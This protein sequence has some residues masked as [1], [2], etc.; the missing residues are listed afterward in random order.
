MFVAYVL[1][2]AIFQLVFREK[3]RA[4]K[5]TFFI[6][7]IATILYLY[8]FSESVETVIS[9]IVSGSLFQIAFLPPAVLGIFV[10]GGLQMHLK[11]TLFVFGIGTLF[12]IFLYPKPGN[13][14]K[15]TSFKQPILMYELP[16]QDPNTEWTLHP[17]RYDDHVVCSCAGV[18][19]GNNFGN[20]PLNFSLCMGVTYSC[21]TET[22]DLCP[23]TPQGEF[24][25]ITVVGDL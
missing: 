12:F 22:V 18:D 25:E 5:F 4:I 20:Y 11:K 6:I 2:F 14:Y 16:F 7:W 3:N 17:I 19:L 9:A 24:C 23:A 15:K 21:S 1:L 13:Y 10:W 8:L